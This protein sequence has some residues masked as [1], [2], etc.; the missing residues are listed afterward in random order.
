MNKPASRRWAILTKTYRGD[1]DVFEKLCASIDAV[2]PDVHHYVLIDSADRPLFASF[3][4]TRRIIV[5]C[6]SQLPRFHPL[7]FLGR[8]LWWRFPHRIVRGWIYQQLAKIE[9][10]SRLSEEAIVLVDSDARFIRPISD[11]NVFEGPAIRLHQMPG[12]P[13]GPAGESDKWHDA[14][15]QALGLPLRGYTGADYI[16]NPVVWSPEV[17]RQMIARI[18]SVHAR[19]WYD[20]LI[21]NFRFSECVLYGVF[22]DHVIGPQQD[23]VAPLDNQMCHISW[24]YDLSAESGVEDFV[25]SITDRHVAVIVQSNLHLDPSRRESI[26]GRFAA[27]AGK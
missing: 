14:A 6:S 19:R 13:S 12:Q 20:V 7:S 26:Y 15:S 25:S 23:L 2:M 4:S 1:L 17:V 24:H 8:P 22:C 11:A 5:D 9:A 27:Q 18:E 16:T 21:R 3:A 10:V